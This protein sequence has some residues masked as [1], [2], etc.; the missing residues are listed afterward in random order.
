MEVEG[1]WVCYGGGGSHTGGFVYE[2]FDN[3]F[4]CNYEGE[5]KKVKDHGHNQSE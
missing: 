1:V 4:V 3:V 5:D 2:G